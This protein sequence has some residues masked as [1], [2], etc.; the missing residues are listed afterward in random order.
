MVPTEELRASFPSAMVD[1]R[2]VPLAEM[3]ALGSDILGGAI[4]RVLPEPS[5]SPV[6]VAAFQSSI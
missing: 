1:L 3:S 5:A 4:G 2:D 6:P